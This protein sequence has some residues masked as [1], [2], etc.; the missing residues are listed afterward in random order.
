MAAPDSFKGSCS[1]ATAADAMLRG[2]RSVFGD[3]A[4]YLALPLADGGEGTLDAMRAAWGQ[5][6][7]TVTTTDALGR[8]R[9]ARYVMS[10]DRRT[11][12]I[13]AAEANGLPWVSD[14]PLRPLDADTAG[15]GVI[16]LEALAEG[17]QELLLS[18]G[19]SATSDGGTGLLT[20][21]GA[22]FLDDD[23]AAVLPGA[24][25]LVAIARIDVSGLD[26]RARAA[27]WRIAVDVDNPLCGPRGAAAV[28]GPQKGADE[29]DIVVI[30][31]GLRHLAGVLSEHTGIVLEQFLDRPGLGAAGGLA[32]T[33][34]A[35]LGAETVP[36]SELVADAMGVREAMRGAA[37]VLTGEGRLDSQSLGG[38]VVDLVRRTAPAGTPVVVIAGAVA[39]TA[40]ECRDAGLTA[41]FC[42][43]DGPA[44]LDDLI[45]RAPER[46]AETTAHAC[47]ALSVALREP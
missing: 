32:L 4:E 38:K 25:G 44:S 37:L 33:C 20:A 27:D 15:V 1:A 10:G 16:A 6:F 42:I 35:L 18:I 8:P 2:A 41:A 36:G 23:G 17:A 7:R 47:A 12:L 43:A 39:L 45:D 40:A 19:G 22:R 3:D 5:S 29:E 26:P 31:A 11:A 30:D 13:E 14:Q 46:I 21:L 28:F 9:E 34:V 24:R